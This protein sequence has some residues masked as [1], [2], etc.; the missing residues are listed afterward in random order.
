M[1]PGNSFATK[2]NHILVSCGLFNRKWLTTNS[3]PRYL[4]IDGVIHGLSQCWS[5]RYQIVVDG[6]DCLNTLAWHICYWEQSYLALIAT[7]S[8]PCS[9]RV[10]TTAPKSKMCFWPK[11]SLKTYS[12][13][14]SENSCYINGSLCHRGSCRSTQFVKV[15]IT[16]KNTD[17]EAVVNPFIPFVRSR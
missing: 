1:R 8:C 10:I 16:S 13:S 2:Y 3:H 15:T 14:Q 5:G 7:G 6:Y 9:R 11:F 12:Y 17:F 4:L